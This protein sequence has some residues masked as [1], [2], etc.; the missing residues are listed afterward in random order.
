MIYSH[1]RLRLRTNLSRKYQNSIIKCRRCGDYYNTRT[2][3]QCDNTSIDEPL[4]QGI[5]GGPWWTYNK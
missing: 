5:N 2:R 4:R 1:H 3:H